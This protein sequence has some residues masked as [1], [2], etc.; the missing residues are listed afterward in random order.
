MVQMMGSYKLCLSR[1]PELHTQPWATATSSPELV[2]KTFLVKTWFLMFSF[3][4]KGN[5]HWQGEGIWSLTRDNVATA[6]P[7]ITS[8]FNGDTI[9]HKCNMNRDGPK[10]TDPI[11]IL[12]RILSSSRAQFLHREMT[13]RKNKWL[14]DR[15]K[16]KTQVLCLM[17]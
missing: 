1:Y 3:H 2:I 12:E 9:V 6:R 5:C 13:E 17:S 10:S 7:I 15:D 4:V 16:D 11:T 14:N 8:K